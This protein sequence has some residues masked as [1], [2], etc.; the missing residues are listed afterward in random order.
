MPNHNQV[1]V[2]A[3]A[4]VCSLVVMPV[5][6]AGTGAAQ[7]EF[8]IQ[9]QSSG[10]GFT[11]LG[12]GWSEEFQIEPVGD[13][14][15]EFGSDTS[16]SVRIRRADTE[17]VV[18]L[19]P[20]DGEPTYEVEEMDINAETIL[21]AVKGD[22][23]YSPPSISVLTPEGEFKDI[24]VTVSG[25]V[26]MFRENAFD[27]YVIEIVGPDG[28][29]LASTNAQIHAVRYEV[30]VEYNGS[31]LAFTRPPSAQPG[32]HVELL[33]DLDGDG[34]AGS[35]E[36]VLEFEH[37]VGDEF[38]VAETDGTV[39]NESKRIEVNIY[40]NESDPLGYRLGAFSIPGEEIK[41]VAGPVGDSGDRGGGGD[42]A[43]AVADYA[44]NRGV[45]NS[46]GLL[47]AAADFRTGKIDATTLLD[48][49]AA[50]RSG[51]PVT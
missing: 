26:D 10:A 31:A 9:Y 8:D 33:Q 22:T 47:D 40:E 37:D 48:V 45:V 28:E 29:V 13:T 23:F 15:F 6:F 39:F 3:F 35:D 25:D 27:P 46:Q 24:N 36:Q 34:F 18:T 2:M 19:Q 49:A 5:T 30:S 43:D 38:F 51:E 4:M 12:S 41:D 16:R 32:W 20:Q 42:L 50:F 1:F 21:A 7:T 11:Y 17:E 14:P 44:N